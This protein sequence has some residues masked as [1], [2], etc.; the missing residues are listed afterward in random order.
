[1]RLRIVTLFLVG[2]GLVFSTAAGC[3]VTPTVATPHSHDLSPAP[4]AISSDADQIVSLVNTQRTAAGCD[5]LTVDGSMVAFAQDHVEFMANGG[6]FVHSKLGP[7]ILAE[8]LSQGFDTP[9]EIV[10]A[11]MDSPAHKQNILNCDYTDTGVAVSGDFAVQEFG[12][13]KS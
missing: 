4:T 1:M 2:L 3:P 9:Q 8:N 10:D 7:P 12:N 5:A 11:W 13:A 6:G